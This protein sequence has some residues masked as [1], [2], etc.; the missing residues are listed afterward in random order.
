MNWIEY[1]I[2][3][4]AAQLQSQPPLTEVDAWT[5]HACESL[6]ARLEIREGRREMSHRLTAR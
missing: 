4:T 6:I 5:L 3:R 2:A 1:A